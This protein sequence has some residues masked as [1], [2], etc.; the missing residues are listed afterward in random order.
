MMSDAASVRP[1]PWGDDPTCGA[2]PIRDI[3]QQFYPDYLDLHPVTWVQHKTANAIANCKTGAFGYNAS[4]CEECSH[5]DIHAC[6]CNNRNCPNCQAPQEKKWVMAR[7]AELIEGVAYY[8]LI[9]TVPHQLNNLIYANQKLLYDLLFKCASDT[10]LALCKDPDYMG[11]TPGIISVLHSWGQQ[12]NLHPHLH[13]MVSGGGL[14]R[15]GQFVETKHKSFIIP[16]EVIGKMFRG[17]YMAALKK[18]WKAGK[19][20]F[21]TS[22]SKLRNRF[23][24]K[25]FADQMYGQTW[26]PFV[27]ET[28]NGKGNAIEYLAR[29][30]YRT[31]ISNS[32]IIAV[33]EETVSFRYTDYAD[34]NQ[35]KVKTVSG[36]EFIRLFL[37]HVPPKGFNRVRFSGFLT[38]C[39][40]TKKLKLIHRLRNTIYKGNPIKDL[41]M[42]DLMMLLFGRDICHC[43]K[44]GGNL[45]RLPRGVPLSALQ[46]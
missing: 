11:A 44:C 41:V 15:S 4:Y 43:R 46:F 38:N 37:Q 3:F 35:K 13:T 7:N 24:W 19:L 42:A 27:K 33:D 5:G 29:Y 28:F 10:I 20:L 25:E 21:D 12:L 45:I 1:T 2:Y 18:Y 30:A 31:A 17:K 14:N 34:Q 8:H 23:Y 6:S 16:V 9:F 22:C 39:Q 26:L 36:T 32:R 40:K